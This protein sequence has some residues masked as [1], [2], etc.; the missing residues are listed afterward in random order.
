MYIL[1][2]LEGSRLYLTYI[3]NRLCMVFAVAP[4]NFF[5]QSLDFVLNYSEKTN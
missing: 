2:R 5:L 4:N 1:V 3:Q